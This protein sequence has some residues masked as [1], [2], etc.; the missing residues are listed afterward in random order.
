MVIT[1][2]TTQSNTTLDVRSYLE[3]PYEECLNEMQNEGYRDKDLKHI[4]S[5]AQRGSENLEKIFN[6]DWK[7]GLV[8]GGSFFSSPAYL[9]AVKTASGK[10]GKLLSRELSQDVDIHSE[11]VDM[12]LILVDISFA[13]LAGA[14]FKK[15]KWLGI[16]TVPGASQPSVK[17]RANNQIELLG[18]Y[19]QFI[20]LDDSY[21]EKLYEKDILGELKKATVYKLA[22]RYAD[23]TTTAILKLPYRGTRTKDIRD[24]GRLMLASKYGLELDRT[25]FYAAA[26][27]TMGTEWKKEL[28]K[29]FEKKAPEY[30]ETYNNYIC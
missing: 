26:E 2:V 29:V 19:L 28:R 16:P 25:R 20:S 18:E 22:D 14:T 12:L 24:I 10:N 21:F 8:Y 23:A 5:C 3:K 13:H 11:E 4:F 6:K 30:L 7:K 17:E 27:K 9:K 15:S 1:F